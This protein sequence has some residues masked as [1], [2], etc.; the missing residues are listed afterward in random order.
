MNRA[1]IM[2]SG[3]EGLLYWRAVL[4]S[5]LRDNRQKWRCQKLQ[6]QMRRQ[7]RR[8]RHHLVRGSA[9]GLY[10]ESVTV[11]PVSRRERH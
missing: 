7:L 5:I 9:G 4:G 6:K 2:Q 1:W 3:I 8:P 10:V 11:P